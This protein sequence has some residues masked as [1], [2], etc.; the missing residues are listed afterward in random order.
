MTNIVNVGYHST[1]YYALDLTRGKLL[2]DCGWPNTLPQFVA[3]MKRKG[4]VPADIKY[5]LATHFHPDH[6]GL[7]EQLKA[8]GAVLL[9]M[10]SQVG[11]LQRPVESPGPKL[12][13]LVGV[14]AA[15][16][17][18]L[19]FAESR[20]FLSSLGLAGEII[21]T[22]GHSDDSVTLI[23]DEGSAFTGDLP[24]RFALGEGSA[25][26][27]ASWDEIYRHRVTH[28]YPAHGN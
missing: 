7:V 26:A 4:M 28:I 15:G 6:A 10:E 17:R 14:S 3:A 2:V 24:P 23:L 8:S 20:Q 13:A 19:T 27:E 9:L 16:T 22:P 21:P 12:P 25:L 18:L 1:N 5:V 11:A